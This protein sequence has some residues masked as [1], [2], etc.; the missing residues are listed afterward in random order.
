VVYEARG[1]LSRFVEKSEEEGVSIEVLQF[2]RGIAVD[3]A[4]T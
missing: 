3:Q 2:D 4:Y 1:G